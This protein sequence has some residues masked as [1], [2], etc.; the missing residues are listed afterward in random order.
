[1]GRATGCL[2]PSLHIFIAALHV[3][4]LALAAFLHI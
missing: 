2:H 3:A 1:V 4:A